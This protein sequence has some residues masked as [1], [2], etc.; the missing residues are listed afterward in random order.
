M[1]EAPVAP[2]QIEPRP[3][4]P[5]QPGPPKPAE[6]AVLPSLFGAGYG[7]YRTKPTSFIYSYGIVT[8]LGILLVFV[9]SMAPPVVQFIEQ[10]APTELIL[11]S[12]PDQSA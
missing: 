12:P 9:A 6:Q 3:P 4:A 10:Q 1:P 8:I 2:Q 11:N 7:T 5:K